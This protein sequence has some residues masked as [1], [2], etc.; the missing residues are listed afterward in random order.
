[1]EKSAGCT[2]GELKIIIY[3]QKFV[4]DKYKK[5]SIHV[6]NDLVHG[7]WASLNFHEFVSNPQSLGFNRNEHD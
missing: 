3:Q 4:T 2:V 1:L 6:K 5:I 7:V